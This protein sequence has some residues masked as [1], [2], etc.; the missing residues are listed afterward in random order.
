MIVLFLPIVV[1]TVHVIPLSVREG[2]S[3]PLA[4]HR[5]YGFGAV[6]K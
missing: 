1:A 6:E 3:K 5:K 4:P 2:H